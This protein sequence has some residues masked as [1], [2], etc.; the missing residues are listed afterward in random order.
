MEQLRDEGNVNFESLADALEHMWT[1][2]RAIWQYQ[3][4]TCVPNS[5]LQDARRASQ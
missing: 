3:Q 2:L 1:A 4:V 5:N